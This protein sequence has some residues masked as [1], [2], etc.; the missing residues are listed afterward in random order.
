MYA[1]LSI[2]KYL[3]ADLTSGVG[4]GTEEIRGEFYLHILL[5]CL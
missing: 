3:Q 2:L 1:K 5:E 4:T